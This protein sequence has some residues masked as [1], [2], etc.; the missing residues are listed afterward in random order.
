MKNQ[1]F[2]LSFAL[3]FVACTAEAQYTGPSSSAKVM[4]VKEVRKQA[5]QLDRTD[6]HI[7]VKGR[8]VQQ[9][10]KNTFWFEDE[11]GKLLVEIEK[12]HFPTF[13]FSEQ[14]VVIITGEVDY[15]ELEETE[16]EAKEIRLAN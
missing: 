6:T 2:I 8:I 11:T 16:I 15:D 1:F 9:I 13:T 14:T 3:L 7:T 12:K 4:T 10:N 5:S